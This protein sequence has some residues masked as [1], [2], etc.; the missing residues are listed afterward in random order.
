MQTGAVTI[1]VCL[2]NHTEKIE[3]LAMAASE[4]FEVQVEKGLTLLTIRHYNEAVLQKMV[5]GRAIELMQ[6][7]PETVQVVMKR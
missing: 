1:Q 2:D 7:T 3:K 4:F 6:Q 5:A